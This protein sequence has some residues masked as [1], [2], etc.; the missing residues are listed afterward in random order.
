[1]AITSQWK[2]Y[3]KL[4]IDNTKVT[5]DLA[6]FPVLLVWTGSSSTSNLPQ[7]MFD[8]NSAEKALVTGNDIRFSSDD[9]GATELPFEIVYFDVNASGVASSRAQVWVKLTSIADT[10][11]TVFYVWWGNANASAY[12]ATDT[13]G[14][15]NVWTNSYRCVYHL[16]SLVDSTGNLANLTEGANASYATDR[17]GRTTGCRY[18]PNTVNTDRTPALGV[19]STT[20]MTFTLWLKRDGSQIDYNGFLF[21]RDTINAVG[22]NFNDTD[23]LRYHWSDQGTTYTW[24]SNLT[25]GTDWS[26]ISLRISSSVGVYRLNGTEATNTTTHNAV[27]FTSARF[28]IGREELVDR[29]FNGWMDSVRFSNTTRTAEW[30]AAE[31]NSESS[32]Q[33]FLTVGTVN[34]TSSTNAILFSLNY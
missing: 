30:V 24:V 25:T 18:Y 7:S 14:R 31:Y 8:T 5:S 6:N 3:C 34:K 11:D 21:S 28:Y 16:N 29:L 26:F 23:K 32:P 1:M 19:G 17:F 33:T 13:F 10:T 4:T 20:A 27:N 15:N 12:A 2:Y 22:L 9:K